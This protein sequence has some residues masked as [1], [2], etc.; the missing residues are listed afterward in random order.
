[1]EV[2]AEM[3]VY[4]YL[5][6]S[7]VEQ[8][9][10]SQYQ[11][12][13]QKLQE[14]GVQENEINIFKDEAVSGAVKALERPEFSKLWNELKE[15]DVLIVSELSRLGRRIADVVEVLDKLVNEKKVRVISAKENLDSEKDPLWFSVFSTLIGLFAN[16][17]REMIRKRVKE[18][19][20]RARQEGKHLGR[21]RQLNYKAILELYGEGKKISRIA[22]LLGYEYSSVA[23]VVRRAKEKG[24][25]KTTETRAIKIDWNKAKEVYHFD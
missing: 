22:R 9:T 5:R 17:E 15:G 10:D 13:R 8:T 4:V 6:V 19:L 1:M 12:I 21:P 24:V 20:E 25:I 16:L 2:V 14:L 3:S 23:S 7:T 18:G 11:S